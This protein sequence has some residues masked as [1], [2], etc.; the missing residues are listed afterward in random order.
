MARRDRGAR[1]ERPVARTCRGTTPQLIAP[2]IYLSDAST[3][4]LSATL[5]APNGGG[6]RATIASAAA[7]VANETRDAKA[8]AGKHTWDSLQAGVGYT[9][10][11]FNNDGGGNEVSASASA[12]TLDMNAA[13]S[14]YRATSGTTCEDA[15]PSTRRVY[16]KVPAL[17][18]GVAVSASLAHTTGDGPA[19]GERLGDPS[20]VNASQTAFAW[21][22]LLDDRSF[23]VTVRWTD[24][25]NTATKTDRTRTPALATPTV[26]TSNRTTRSIKATGAAAAGNGT[27]L[28]VKQGASGTQFPSPHTFDPLTSGTSYTF[29]AVNTDGYNEATSPGGASTTAAMPAVSCTAQVTDSV[30]PGAIRVTAGASSTSGVSTQVSLTQSGARQASGYTFGSLGAGSYRPY[31]WVTDDHNTVSAACG[32][33][34]IN[35]PAPVAVSASSITF[36]CTAGAEWSV[37]WGAAPGA[38]SYRYV[39]QAVNASGVWREVTSGQ[40]SGT[41][42]TKLQTAGNVCLNGVGIKIQAY[43]SSGNAVWTAKANVAGEFNP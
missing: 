38:T 34:S 2:S 14:C 25:F 7:A 1:R 22:P 15:T 13:I 17:R 23:E 42:L 29:Y 24:G 36:T 43:N 21:D 26:A 28:K 40:T 5:S 32:T 12:S 3:R 10:T 9:V 20:S 31:A 35:A 18:P 37:A 33:Q 16:V 19:S 41:S 27:S 30:A 6:F 8:G 39:T 11:G 4:A